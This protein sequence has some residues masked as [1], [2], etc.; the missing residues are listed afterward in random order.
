MI[1][2]VVNQTIDLLWG[3]WQGLFLMLERRAAWTLGVFAVT[4]ILLACIGLYGVLAYAVSG[5]R[6]E[7]GVLMALGAPRREIAGIFLRLGLYRA[8]IR[9]M[10][11]QAI[12]AVITAVSYSTLVLGATVFFIWRHDVYGWWL[13]NTYYAKMD[14][15][16]SA[17][18]ARGWAYLLSFLERSEIHTPLAAALAGGVLAVVA[19]RRS[20]RDGSP[21]G[22]RGTGDGPVPCVA[23]AT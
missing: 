14:G 21:A 19:H 2:T 18:L 22:S 9:F 10:G 8:V 4:A 3:A 1:R 17:Q 7:I 15:L 11:Q 6:H 5:R 23:F 20:A 16:R 12:W 13:P